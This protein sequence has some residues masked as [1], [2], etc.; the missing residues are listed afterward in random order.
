MSES[1]NNMEQDMEKLVNDYAIE[2]FKKGLNCS[3]AVYEALMR[4]GVLNVDKNTLAL[5][6]GFGGGIGQYGATCG[7]LSAAVMANSAVFG[8]KNPYDSPDETRGTEIAQKYYR[9]YNNIAK[10]FAER[11]GDTSCRAICSK[12]EDWH[13]KERRVNCMKLVGAAAALAYR[14]LQIPQDEAFELPYGPNMGGNV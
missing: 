3:E 6:T 7:A 9:R 4:A 12:W 5:C 2:N 8:R 13:C 14:Y 10:D 11:N 1:N